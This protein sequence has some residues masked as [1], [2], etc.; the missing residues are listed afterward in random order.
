[1]TLKWNAFYHRE[2]ISG[3]SAYSLSPWLMKIFDGNNL[4][5]AQQ[6]FNRQLCGVRQIIERC[7]GL[8][9]V[10]FRCILGERKLRYH[11]TKVG[12]IVYACATLHNFLISNRFNI[13]RDIDEDLLQNILLQNNVHIVNVQANLPA[14]Q[15]RRNEVVNY[16]NA[17][18]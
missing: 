4:T 1:M 17:Q 6:H 3:D 8:L 18:L 9:K 5:A 13:N 2:K 16:L 11:P 7:I 15:A 10:R 12:K 14:G